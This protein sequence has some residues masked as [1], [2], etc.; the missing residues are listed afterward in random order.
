MDSAKFNAKDET[1]IKFAIAVIPHHP[2]IFKPDKPT[3]L[4]ILVYELLLI[5]RSNT[6]LHPSRLFICKNLRTTNPSKSFMV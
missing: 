2:I 5:L 6:V 3:L 4:N 1:E